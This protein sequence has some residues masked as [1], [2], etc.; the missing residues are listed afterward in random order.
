MHTVDA[1]AIGGDERRWSLRKAPGRW[2]PTCDPEMSEWG[3]PP[4]ISWVSVP[5]YIGYWRRTQGT[6]TSK[7]LEEKKSNEIPLVAASERGT[8]ELFD[9]RG[10]VWEVWP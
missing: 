9:G 5:E 10:T 4:N 2:Q 8:A 1:L 6:E 7:Y 3:N